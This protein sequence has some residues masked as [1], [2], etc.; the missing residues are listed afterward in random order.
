VILMCY[1]YLLFFFFDI[2]RYNFS[3]FRD[4]A[5]TLVVQL[6]AFHWFW[7]NNQFYY[8]Y[9]FTNFAKS[10]DGFPQDLF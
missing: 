7:R 5:K 3:C 6:L 1:C 9:H 2:G 8:F 10:N 4:F